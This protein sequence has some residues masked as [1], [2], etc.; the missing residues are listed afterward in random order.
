MSWRSSI[1]RR[2]EGYRKWYLMERRSSAGRTSLSLLRKGFFSNR[3]WLYP[4]D[5]FA[6]ESFLSDWEIEFRLPKLNS[7]AARQLFADKL[8]FHERARGGAF[9][10]ATTTFLGEFSAGK[11]QLANGQETLPSEFIAKPVR[12]SGGRG[13]MRA[14]SPKELDSDTDYLLEEIVQAAD[15]ARRIYP[16]TINTIRVLT[17]RDPVTD[18]VFVLG[19][20]HRFATQASGPVDNFKSGGIV[21]LVDSETAELSAAI[22]NTGAPERKL[23]DCHPETGEKIAGKV[24]PEWEQIKRCSI[25]S[26]SAVE[27]LHYIGW[28]VALSPEGPILI[29]G[30]A[31]LPNPNLLQFHRPVLLDQRSRDFFLHTGV[32]SRQKHERL[33]GLSLR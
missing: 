26:M 16:N 7:L 19:A 13:V 29:E 3:A 31:T 21:S 24:V 23:F 14:S 28:D 32:I 18:E 4:L 2:I 9:A 20:A 25:Q 6:W 10:F 33:Q 30:N 17:V 1:C 8:R 5:Q 11:I 12:G 22:V 15:Y 27:G